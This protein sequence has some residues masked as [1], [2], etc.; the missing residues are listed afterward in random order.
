MNQNNLTFCQ[1]L[2]VSCKTCNLWD[3]WFVYKKPGHEANNSQSAQSNGLNIIHLFK[4]LTVKSGCYLRLYEASP[5]HKHVQSR[6]EQTNTIYLCYLRLFLR[7]GSKNEMNSYVSFL[8]FWFVWLLNQER[9]IVPITVIAER[10]VPLLHRPR[11]ES[12]TYSTRSRQQYECLR[13][14]LAPFKLTWEHGPGLSWSQVL[15]TN[16]TIHIH[17]QSFRA[18]DF[19]VFSCRLKRSNP[20]PSMKMVFAKVLRFHSVPML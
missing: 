10:R 4:C 14:C 11:I 19:A 8:W 16:S 2:Y 7:N 9:T 3:S 5:M 12:G 1:S 6:V 17:I 18:V 13:Q 20:K 15:F